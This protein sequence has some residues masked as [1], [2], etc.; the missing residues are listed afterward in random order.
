MTSSREPVTVLLTADELATVLAA[1]RHWQK[2]LGEDSRLP[3]AYPQFDGFRP[4][5]VVEIDPLCARLNSAAEP[6]DCKLPGCY[7]SGVPGVI[8]RMKGGMLAPGAAVERCDLCCRYESDEA[9]RQKLTELGLTSSHS[10]LPAGLAEALDRA[11]EALGQIVQSL[12][13]DDE[14]PDFPRRSWRNAICESLT[15]LGYWH[16]VAFMLAIP[17]EPP[18]DA[19]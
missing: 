16:W 5:T 18:E 7:H 17:E 13:R 2:Q 14:W 9:A 11:D 12:G 3:E 10:G 19:Q 1:L 8:A 4:L 15:S 6:C